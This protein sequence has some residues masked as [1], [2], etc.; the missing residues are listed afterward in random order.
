MSLLRRLFG[1]PSPAGAPSPQNA[2]GLDPKAKVLLVRAFLVALDP[3]LVIGIQRDGEWYL[4][5]GIVEG[6]GTPDGVPRG[7]HFEPLAQHLLSQTG[8]RLTGLSDAVGLGMFPAPDGVEATVLFVGKAT[9]AQTGGT[10]FSLD[11]LPEFAK[12]C[13]V[14]HDT[15]RNLCSR[16]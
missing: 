14:T 3:G 8:L 1:R 4:P 12:I 10:Q 6:P 9:D 16:F 15:I 13:A 2:S 5:G 7:S 11:S